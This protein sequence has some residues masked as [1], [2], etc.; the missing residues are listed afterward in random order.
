M[1][2]DGIPQSGEENHGYGAQIIA[3]IAE[4]YGG[5]VLFTAREGI[6]SLKILMPLKEDS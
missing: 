5:D 6:F 2:K 3:A 1:L 4:S